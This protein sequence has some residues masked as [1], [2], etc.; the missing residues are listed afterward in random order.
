MNC[1][2]V[3]DDSTNATKYSSSTAVVE[4]RKKNVDHLYASRLWPSLCRSLLPQTVRIKLRRSLLKSFCR[5]ILL[6]VLN[7]I[8]MELGGTT[9]GSGQRE[10]NHGDIRQCPCYAAQD[11]ARGAPLVWDSR[12]AHHWNSVNI[13]STEGSLEDTASDSEVPD[14]NDSSSGEAHR[15]DEVSFLRKRLGHSPCTV[16]V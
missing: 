4:L 12:H 6:F 15:Q 3:D 8:R 5:R 16:G 1:I 9:A 14:D 13:Y 11:P 2:S 7:D 10:T